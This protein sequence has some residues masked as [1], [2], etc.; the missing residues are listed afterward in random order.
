M[1]VERAGKFRERNQSRSAFRER[2]TADD[3]LAIVDETALSAELDLGELGFCWLSSSMGSCISEK[4][5]K[6]KVSLFFL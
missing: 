5:S 6:F 3:V 1:S 2:V 4:P